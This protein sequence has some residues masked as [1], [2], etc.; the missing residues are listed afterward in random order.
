MQFAGS[1]AHPNLIDAPQLEFA[2]VY[3]PVANITRSNV[4]ST[5]GA[6][7]DVAFSFAYQ[8]GNFQWDLGYN[9]W[10]RS[11]EQLT[12]HGCC[13]PGIGQW[14]L[15]GDE[16]V[17]GFAT[18]TP[19]T[20]ALAT[21]LAATD[22]KANIHTGSNLANDVSY[23]GSNPTAPNN[24]YTDSTVPAVAQ[25]NGVTVLPV[26]PLPLGATSF[27]PGT[28]PVGYIY[29]SAEPVLIQ[30]SDFDLQ[31]TRGISNKIF[32]HFN[33]A[34]PNMNDGKWSPYVG[35]GVEAEFG[36]NDKGCNSCDT[37]CDNPCSSSVCTPT[38]N[39]G[40]VNGQPCGALQSCCPNVAL[41]QWGIW[42]KVG[43]SYN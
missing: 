34:W 16:R 14:A 15:K 32:T 19:G 31:G 43:T 23:T 36:S 28:V 40:Y 2:N 11:C 6:Q 8:H 37:S 13:N 30:E 9:F 4:K 24:F 22:S 3:A 5:I 18:I 1:V 33:Y 21:A 27:T 39:Y 26:T 7:G 35:L 17:Y 12:L 38:C 20:K 42:F 25:Y 29:T 41:S 10:G